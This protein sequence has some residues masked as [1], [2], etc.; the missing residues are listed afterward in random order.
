[1]AAKG[2]P[3]RKAEDR[4]KDKAKERVKVRAKEKAEINPAMAAVRV[5]KRRGEAGRCR[6]EG[7]PRLWIPNS[8]RRRFRSSPRGALVL[9][10]WKKPASANGPG[11]TIATS[12]PTL[13]RR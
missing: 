9:K 13:H 1:M 3:G 11:W 10:P 6:C 7:N 4:V 12:N 2:S 5:E 8:R